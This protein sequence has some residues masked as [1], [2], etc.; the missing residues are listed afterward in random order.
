MA[1]V[2]V[3]TAYLQV[4]R[5]RKKEKL[6]IYI[7]AGEGEREGGRKIEGHT[8]IRAVQLNHDGTS[9]LYALRCVALRCVALRCVALR[10]AALCPQRGI[11]VRM[12]RE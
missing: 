10:C 7:S 9:S 12:Q 3:Q 11:Q 1:T 6:N 8:A 2:G 4:N 5:K